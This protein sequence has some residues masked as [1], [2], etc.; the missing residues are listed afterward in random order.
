MVTHLTPDRPLPTRE[1]L[2]SGPEETS[3]MHAPPASGVTAPVF[4]SRLKAVTERLSIEATYRSLPSGLM[5]TDIAPASPVA[6]DAQVGAPGAC[7]SLTQPL[8]SSFPDFRSRAKIVSVD[9]W[10][11]VT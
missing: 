11:D 1:Q 3:S 6:L 7:G 4:A 8:G 2:A 5:T 10:K 9:A